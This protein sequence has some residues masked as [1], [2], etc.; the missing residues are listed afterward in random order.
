MAT[1]QRQGPSINTVG[2]ARGVAEGAELA[3][4]DLCP[5]RP[6]HLAVGDIH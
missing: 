5:L 4:K 6:R 2:E 1:D 3:S